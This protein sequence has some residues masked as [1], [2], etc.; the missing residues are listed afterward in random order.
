MAANK[1]NEEEIK[2]VVVC[3]CNASM[4]VVDLKIRCCSQNE[5]KHQ[6]LSEII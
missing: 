6:D 2:S 5:R 3:D 1:A 4:G